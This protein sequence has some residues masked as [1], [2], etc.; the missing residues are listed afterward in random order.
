M[1]K[2][3]VYLKRRNIP[4]YISTSAADECTKKLNFTENFFDHVFRTFAEGYFN[5][6]RQQQGKNPSDPI[7]KADFMIFADLFNELRMTMG[8][9]LQK[10]LRELEKQ[11]V[12]GVEQ[13]L[14]QKTKTDFGSFIRLFEGQA[15]V[16]AAHLRIQKVRFLK[17]QQGFFKTRNVLPDKSITARLLTNVHS[18]G[19][20]PF[21]M[22]DADNISSAWVHMQSNNEKTIFASFDF[23]TVI[24][25]AKEIFK[26]INL[27]CCDP[28]YVIHYL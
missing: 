15:L 10:P 9:V 8:S 12:L 14:R 16:L 13:M 4:C 28:L 17:N 5:S 27:H 11:M 21:H 18:S 24:S 25:H 1:D 3:K 19:R 7:T 22:E 23:R 20:F 6:C 2:L 26:L